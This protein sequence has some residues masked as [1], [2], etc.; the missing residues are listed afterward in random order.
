[1]T[2]FSRQGAEQTP[3]ATWPDRA[4]E[5]DTELPTVAIRSAGQH[6]FVYRKMV[7]GTVGA[8]RPGDGDL[9]RVLDRDNRPL[10]FGLWNARSEIRLRILPVGT[11]AR[12]RAFWESRIDRAIALRR[13]TLGLDAVANA[14]RVLH[15]EA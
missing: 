6:P 9:V 10:G 11:E 7:A 15:A 4:L 12:G 5:P 13:E 8:L 14:Y 3:L 2:R 1:M